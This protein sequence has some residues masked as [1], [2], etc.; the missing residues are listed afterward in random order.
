MRATFSVLLV[1][2]LASLTAG[3]FTREPPYPSSPDA[4]TFPFELDSSQTGC[5]GRQCDL[6]VTISRPKFEP[7]HEDTHRHAPF[8]VIFF[9]NGFKVRL[10]SKTPTPEPPKRR[11]ERR[12]GAASL[13][14]SALCGMCRW[15][16][17]SRSV[18]DGPRLSFRVPCRSAAR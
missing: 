2:L 10:P 3:Q 6:T 12:S 9:M 11:W 8:P 1:A 17:G 16:F 4:L 7:G 13:T 14:P 18:A 15:I 5:A